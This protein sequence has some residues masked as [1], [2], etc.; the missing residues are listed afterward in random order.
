MAQGGGSPGKL[1]LVTGASSGIGRATAELFARRGARV[2]L[3]ARSIAK[4]DE[5]AAGIRAAGGSAATFAVDLARASQ[6]DSAAAA[7]LTAHGTPDI[8]VNN[9]GAGRWKPFVETST[10]EA[11]HMMELP[12]LAAFAVTRAFLPAMLKR[13]SGRIAF[14]TSPGSFMVWPNASAYIAARFALRGFAEAL[15]SEVRR[16]GIGVTLVTLGPVASPYWEHNP[17]SRRY[18]PRRLPLLM[19]ELTV[20]QAAETIVGAVSAQRRV[21]VRP[22]VLRLVIALGRRG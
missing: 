19:P 10:D 3:M 9:A 5:V 18:M 11:R 2:L 13:K 1:V 4:L 6:V 14:V 15:R 16:S 12:Y 17:D 7:I 8:V 22:W 21:V 20:G